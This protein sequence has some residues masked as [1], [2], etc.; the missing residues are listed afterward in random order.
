MIYAFDLH[1][2]YKLWKGGD[3]IDW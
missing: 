3:Q 2:F 1:K